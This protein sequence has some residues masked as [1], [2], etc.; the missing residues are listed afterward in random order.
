M[1]FHAFISERSVLRVI[2]RV[3]PRLGGKASSVPE[4]WPLAEAVG[5]LGSDFGALGVKY[6]KP[7]LSPE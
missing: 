5:V 6:R 4:L 3:R 7:F 1:S 2:P